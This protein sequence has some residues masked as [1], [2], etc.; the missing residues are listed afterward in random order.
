MLAEFDAVR[1]DIADRLH[2]GAANRKSV[3]HTPVVSTGDGDMRV[4]V[5]R[6]FEA[7]RHLLRFHCDARSP[8]VA[9]IANDPVVH[10]LCY[11][12]EARVQ[13]RMRGA[14][15]VGID[16]PAAA[17][18]WAKSTNFARRCYLGAAP[19]AYSEKPTSGLPDWA[20]GIQPTDEQI[21]PARPNFAVLLVEVERYDW[22]HLAN[23]GHRRAVLT[24]E[25]LPLG[26]ALKPKGNAMPST[27]PYIPRVSVIFDFD[28]TL[29][30]DTVNA[31]CAAWGIARQEWE[32]QHQQPLGDNWDGILKRGQGVIDCGRERGDPL[33]RAFVARAA[34]HIEL[35]KGVRE[36]KERLADAA[37]GVLSGIEVEMVVL[38]SGFIEMIEQTEIDELF[39]RTWAG[40]FHFDADDVAVGMKRII[41]HPEK[42]RYIEAYAKGLDLD[43]ANEPRV[44][45]PDFSEMDMHV[46]FDQLIYVG[47]GLSDLE[48]FSFVA[49][50]GGVTVAI[51]KSA[52]FDQAEQQTSD[53][54][55]DNLASPD[56]SEGSELLETLRHAVRSAAGRA[57]IRKYSR[58][59]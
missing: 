34:E 55:V 32:T 38:S 12:R 13:L 35:Y 36:L 16:T 7:E 8:K 4:M 27:H 54:R 3:M 41:G 23:T 33:T 51:D 50:R 40:S 31:M 53:E 22:L 20:E 9:A 56:Y 21:A 45:D 52:Q 5:L 11:D 59:E 24:Q 19:G 17:A 28:R 57:A 42:A 47:D 29:A 15:R 30:S 48:A 1:K 37:R 44:D 43:A 46:P 26:R 58:G 2:E 14:G 10:V 39:D 18:A 49:N 25:R 6:S